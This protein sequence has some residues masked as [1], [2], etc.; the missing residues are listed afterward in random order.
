M[1]SRVKGTISR[2]L[3]KP[4]IGE[5]ITFSFYAPLSSRVSVAGSFNGWNAESYQLLRRE[6][7]FWIGEFVMQP[8]RY[9]YM[10]VIDGNWENAQGTQEKVD[11]GMGG[12][13]NVL[14]VE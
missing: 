2:T 3:N 9:E 8:G 6:D 7:G 1:E 10:F 4:K 11:N 14:I 12:F 5:K 13:N